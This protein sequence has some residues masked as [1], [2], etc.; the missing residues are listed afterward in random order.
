MSRQLPG[1]A[2]EIEAAIGL[3]LTAKLLRERGGTDISIPLRAKG[4]ALARIVGR[5]ACEALI[6]EIGPGKIAL[7]C[8]GFRGRDAAR[9]A[10]KARALEMLRAGHSLREV[11]LSCDL[12]QRTVSNY[13]E[14]LGDDRQGKLPL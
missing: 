8:A 11:A 3:E 4:S 1:L 12:A 9:A 10:R 7:P 2:G 14:E 5:A 6:R 13:R